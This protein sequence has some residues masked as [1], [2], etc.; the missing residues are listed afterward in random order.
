MSI[1]STLALPCGGADA[2]LCTTGGRGLV[3]GEGWWD[4]VRTAASVLGTAPQ[5]TAPHRAALQYSQ[6]RA[7]RA[8][9]S[10]ILGPAP[11]LRL[12][13][14]QP[15]QLKSSPTPPANTL[16]PPR[17]PPQREMEVVPYGKNFRLVPEDELPEL[18][19]YLSQHLP[20]SLKFQQTLRTFLT[21]RV[22]DFYFY[23]T[24]DWPQEPVVLHFPGI[25]HPPNGLLYESFSVFCP[26]DRLD[27]LQLLQTEDVLIDWTRPL[28]LNFTPQVI[29]E[30][31]R[32]FYEQIGEIET[33]EGDVYIS[34]QEPPPL[35]ETELPPEVELRQLRRVDAKTIHDLYPARDMECLEAFEKCIATLPAYGIFAKEDED[36]GE[37]KTLAAWM[38]QS[39]YGAMFSMQTLPEFRRKGYGIFLAKRLTA[40]VRK[41]GY[42]PFVVIRP[43]NAASQSLYLKLGFEKLYQTVR[44]VLKPFSE[45]QTDETQSSSAKWC[46]DVPALGATTIEINHQENGKIECNLEIKNGELA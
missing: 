22:W 3:E 6:Q 13:K 40:D 4:G 20:Q 45:I 10:A 25:T 30:R 37:K 15:P 11:H 31:M 14:H 44:A 23:V 27:A 8:L 2:I 9:S 38:V 39:Y 24:K 42:V 28:Y 17:S 12:P 33:V 36:D 41:R 1:V 18:L 5:D 19:D 26:D 46:H 21:D 29:L 43:E 32:E 35:Q 7:R 16:G 34:V